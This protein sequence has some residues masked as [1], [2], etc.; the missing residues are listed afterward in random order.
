[1][2]R[3]EKIEKLLDKY[4]AEGDVYSTFFV[5]G[6]KVDNE[7]FYDLANAALRLEDVCL[8]IEQIIEE[9]EDEL[10]EMRESGES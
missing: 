10:A 1:M 9:L 3:K 5:Y 6:L 2:T 4:Y 8:E 7:E